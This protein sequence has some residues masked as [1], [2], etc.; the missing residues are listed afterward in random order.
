MAAQGQ[1]F[2]NASGDSD[3]ASSTAPIAEDTPYV[4]M[5]GGTTLVTTGAGGSRVSENTWNRG[6]GTGS[7]GGVSPTYAIPL[8]QQGISMNAN[9]GSV[10]MRN[11]PDVACVAENVWVLY[12]NGGSGAFGGTS[13]AAPLW[14]G[15]MA[16]VN[17]QAAANGQPPVGFI[18]PAI[19]V[20]GKSANYTSDF[21]D[22]TTGNNTSTTS[23]SRFFAV[24]GYDL[25]T[26]WGTPKGLNLMDALIQGVGDT[27]AVTPTN[28]LTMSGQAGGPFAPASGV[29]LLANFAG[30][31]N[32]WS[33][34]NTS[35]WFTVSPSSG[36]LL[37][38][39][40]ANVTV[41]VAAAANALPAG[42]YAATLLFS[43][44]TTLA[45]QSRLLTLVVGMGMTWDS[46][47]AG[48][49]PQDG[50]GTWADQSSVAG[51][52]NWWTGAADVLWTNGNP[53][54]ATFGA[55]S[56]VAD[57]VTLGSPVTAAGI[58]FNTTGSGNYTVAGGGNT[59]TL[60]GNVSANIS[61][62]ISAPLTL[63]FSSVF[64]VA[65]GQTL[66]V[67]SVIA[68]G[69]SNNL[70]INGSGTVNLTGQ[71]NTGAS[72]GMAGSVAVNSGTLSLNS[73]STYGT[74]GNVAGITIGSGAMLLLQGTNAISGSSGVAPSITINN[75]GSVTNAGTGNQALGLLTLNGGTLAGAG[76]P[77]AGSFNL[78]GDVFVYSNTT[79]SAQNL[80]MTS[81]KS[82]NVAS[83]ITLTFLGTLI[84]S[85]SLTCGGPGTVILSTNNSFSGGTTINAGTLRVLTSNGLGSASAAVTVGDSGQLQIYTN[86]TG[87]Q[88]LTLNGAGPS[89]TGALHISAGTNTVWTGA[90]TL[91]A[92]A[93]INLDNNMSLAISNGITG[94]G[95]S[96][97]LAGGSGSLGAARGAIS[98]GA[99][100]ISKSG[101]GTWILSGT[102]TFT[103]NLNVDTASTTSSDGILRIASSGAVPS[104]ITAVQIQNNN[105]GSSTLQ[106]DGSGGNISITKPFNVNC[107]AG[108][109]ATIENLSGTNTLS[110]TI[111]LN[112]GGNL[113]N[114]QS[115]AG[116]LVFKGTNQYIGTLTGGRTYAFTG[117]GDFLMAGPILNSTNSAPIGL[118][119]SGAGTL[120]LGGTNTYGNGTTLSGGTLLVNGS[121]TGAVTVAS[122]TTLGGKGIIFS[123]VTI[124]SSAALAPG[125]NSAAIGTLTASN[126]VTLQ[127]GSTTRMKISKMPMTNDVL[128]VAG[129]SGAVNYGGTLVV[130]NLG[131]ILAGGDNFKLFNASSY[132]GSFASSNLP[133]LSAG[134]LWSTS[135]L[136]NGTLSVL[137][138]DFGIAATSASPAPQVGSNAVFTVTITA[139]NGFGGTV[140]LSVNGLPAG[141]SASFSPATIAGSGTS[142]LTIITSNNVAAGN[143]SLSITGTNSDFNLTHNATATLSINDFTVAATPAMQAIFAG[144]GTNFTVNV[145][146]SNGFAGTV[147][148]NVSGL[149]T[150]ASYNLDQTSVSG[151][152]AATLNV[153]TTE[154]VP[155][156]NYLL[157]VSGSS[158]SL[159]H[160]IQIHLVVLHLP[161]NLAWNS[162]AGADWDILSST[163]WL[164][165]N[166]VAAAFFYQGD[167]VFFGDTP[168]VVTNINLAAAAQPAGVT[169][170]AGTNNYS[171]SGAGKITGATGF[172]KRGGSTFT[173]ATTNDFTGSTIIEAGTLALVSGGSLDGSVTIQVA[174]GAL[175]DASGRDDGALTL[176]SGQTLTGGG[177]L[178][179]NVFIN[180]GAVLSPG[181]NSI[182]LLT[183]SNNLTLQDGSTNW[184][185]LDKS[186]ATNDQL[187]VGGNLNCAGDLVV[188]NLAGTLAAG[189]SFKLF[190]AA[191]YSGTFASSNLPPLAGG[192][193]W[194][195]S[196]LTNNGSLSIVQIVAT[197]PVP[198]VVGLDGS[199]LT[200]SWPSD[201]TGWHLQAQTNDLGTGLGTNWTDVVGAT[202]TNQMIFQIDSA[203]GSIFYRLIYP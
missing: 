157:T 190:S 35:S 144:S 176:N 117:A 124:P 158:G 135:G 68:G 172:V 46:S 78:T 171:I 139:S 92:P 20:I 160:S 200:L 89:S 96:L 22:I 168:G 115:D 2:F 58:N 113:F 83:G 194:N 159:A 80:T 102:N 184:M 50:P 4:T 166:T 189:D 7:T 193:Y 55:N 131:G 56:G 202:T 66:T 97:T 122:S 156:N 140:A 150:G 14:A 151:S 180:S 42:Y 88:P 41:T 17:Q 48:G 87:T 81:G 186:A 118:T 70:A 39:A 32:K 64:T 106:L 188:S 108:T 203:S 142:T 90:I 146:A 137:A 187:V 120:T 25:A 201:H 104:G 67:G 61:A 3:A 33:L 45:V 29:F 95:Y 44:Q 75:G 167:T 72:A 174:P 133:P 130:T 28:G 5:V 163:N 141:T 12:N 62:V 185:E 23:P 47:A 123:T 147:T 30:T 24:T 82:I 26:G 127:S 51:N 126:L 110:S 16:L 57:V 179:G 116:L 27:L 63:G 37:S 192:L 11:V 100:S 19:Y 86:F 59:L 10:F 65:A 143:Y 129:A 15:Y 132:S 125:T 38:G 109:V 153:T 136:T 145:G 154:L 36:T 112:T 134:L 162:F 138:M 119:K 1:S 60:N 101:A 84:G 169:V 105:S 6:D 76:N 114:L 21:N 94:S 164:D 40:S 196:G 18:N 49:A 195:T 107:R 191:S 43:N 183:I 178:N 99:G 53:V 175:L 111:W 181:N 149:P 182:G 98:I 198:I 93:T 128:R 74:L 199:L 69:V 52:T 197:N 155:S 152:G 31:T 79:V 54:V 77:T 161:A 148:L 103:G 85:G 34:V 170:D 121:I 173:L 177:A 165:T 73:S 13:C 8:W 71:N 9:Q 91:G